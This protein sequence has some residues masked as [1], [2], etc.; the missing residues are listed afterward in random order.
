[1]SDLIKVTAAEAE[2]I[3]LKLELESVWDCY[4]KARQACSTLNLMIL[5][6]LCR[7]EL[8]HQRL[9]DTPV[10]SEFGD[11]DRMHLKVVEELRSAILHKIELEPQLKEYRRVAPIVDRLLRL[12][13]SVL[14]RPLRE[15]HLS[16]IR[17][18]M[19]IL[20]PA[21]LERWQAAFP[22]LNPP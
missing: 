10:Q 6:C 7:L 4:T 3:A 8:G 17:D 5:D 11:F 22:F 20:G 2:V 1:M 9:L 16:A 15:K 19:T 21:Q 12:F 18:V 13:P 14:D